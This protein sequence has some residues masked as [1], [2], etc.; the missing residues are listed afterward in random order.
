MKKKIFY[1]SFFLII[2][3]LISFFTPA[4]R[5]KTT[6]KLEILSTTAM[7]HS[8][9]KEIVQDYTTTNL[10][11]EGEADPH[12]YQMKKGDREKIVNADIIFGNGLSLEHNPSL[13]YLLRD[14]GAV[15]LG[16]RILKKSKLLIITSQKEIDPHIWMDLSLMKEAV[17]IIEQEVCQKDPQNK[18]VYKLNASILKNKMDVLD[19]KILSLMAE[20]P[21]DKRY[22]VSSHDAFNYFVRRYFNSE[23]EGRLFSMQGLSPEAEVSLKRMNKVIDF[24]KNHKVTT[25]FYESNLPKDCLY[26]IIEV[27]KGFSIEVKICEDPLYG[28]TLGSMTYLEMIEHNANVIAK[29]LKGGQKIG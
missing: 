3:T 15:F 6:G 1:F 19:K 16:D 9:V 25:I 29:N 24:I 11:M 18:G 20:I 4:E 2:V 28:D 7:I 14:K 22:L 8:L 12:S 27:C 17:D 5:E 26:K 23:T 13:I 10:L 21:E